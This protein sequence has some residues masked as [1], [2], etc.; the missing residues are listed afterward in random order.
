MKHNNRNLRTAVRAQSLA[1]E[2][3][4]RVLCVSSRYIVKSGNRRRQKACSA[5]HA[6]RTVTMA[7]KPQ[8]ILVEESSII[9]SASSLSLTGR[10]YSDGNGAVAPDRP[11]SRQQFIT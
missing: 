1:V 11:K 2:H 5:G 7:K 9:T 4:L 3:D 10:V 8:K 6:V